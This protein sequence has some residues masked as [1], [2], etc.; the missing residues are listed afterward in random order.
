MRKGLLLFL[1]VL[2][3]CGTTDPKYCHYEYTKY[4]ARAVLNPDGTLTYTSQMV[5]TDS[6]RVCTVHDVQ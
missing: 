3:G 6:V 1:V 2:A 4:T 5:P